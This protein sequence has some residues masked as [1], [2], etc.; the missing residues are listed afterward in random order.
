MWFV[1]LD[2]CI[3]EI[4]NEEHIIKE[5]LSNISAVSSLI[6]LQAIKF[7]INGDYNLRYSRSRI[8]H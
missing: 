8:Y 5:K 2:L 4:F 7:L 1:I 3:H 6:G